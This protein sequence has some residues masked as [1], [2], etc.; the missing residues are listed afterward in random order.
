MWEKEGSICVTRVRKSPHQFL[1]GRRHAKNTEGRR[2]DGNTRLHDA[3]LVY[4]Q[5]RLSFG[6]VGRRGVCF[7]MHCWDACLRIHCLSESMSGENTPPM[8]GRSAFFCLCGFAVASEIRAI[9]GTDSPAGPCTLTRCKLGTLPLYEASVDLIRGVC[10]P[11][12]IRV[13]R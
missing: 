9:G 10:H 2:H 12:L 3:W 8:S 6:W 11:S 7:R 5:L 1:N 13:S 4:W